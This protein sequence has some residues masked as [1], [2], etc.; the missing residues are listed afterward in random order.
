M[1]YNNG[2]ENKQLTVM[3]KTTDHEIVS[4]ILLMMSR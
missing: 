1:L 4:L 2:S 3:A